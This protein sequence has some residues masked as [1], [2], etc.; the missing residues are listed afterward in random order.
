MLSYTHYFVNVEIFDTWPV[1]GKRQH[2]YLYVPAAL[3][4]TITA[5]LCFIEGLVVLSN[6]LKA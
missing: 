4:L 6:R 5:V 2:K 1:R 3:F